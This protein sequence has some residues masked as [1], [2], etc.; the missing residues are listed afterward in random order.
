[1]NTIRL[2]HLLTQLDR[3]RPPRLVM[4]HSRH[5]HT[6]AHIPGSQPIQDLDDQTVVDPDEPVVLYCTGDLCGATLTAY[7]QLQSRGHSDIRVLRGGLDGWIQAG[8]PVTGTMY[9]LPE[10]VSA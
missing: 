10:A 6:K 2:D 9:D 1:M 5:H 3:Q 7:R 8:L 4:T